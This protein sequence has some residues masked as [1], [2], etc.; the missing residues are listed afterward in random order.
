MN[1]TNVTGLTPQDLNLP[2][3]EEV[4]AGKVM[5]FSPCLHHNAMILAICEYSQNEEKFVPVSLKQIEKKLKKSTIESIIPNDLTI[6][7]PI[8]ERRGMIKRTDEGISLSI[9]AKEL[10][11]QHYAKP[12]SGN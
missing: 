3:Y 5:D 4:F 10:L 9:K 8:L 2:S 11:Y 7:V 12:H 6:D 1:E